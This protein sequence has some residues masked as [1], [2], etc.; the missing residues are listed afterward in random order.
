V[1][2]V[3]SSVYWNEMDDEDCLYSL[4][5]IGMDRSET[6]QYRVLESRRLKFPS[7]SYQSHI[8]SSYLSVAYHF[9]GLYILFYL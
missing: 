6:A 9:I 3:S 7:V 2:L 5:T 8:L 4:V 1:I